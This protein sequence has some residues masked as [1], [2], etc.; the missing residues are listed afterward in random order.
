MAKKVKQI[1]NFELYFIFKLWCASAVLVLATKILRD[2]RKL[3]SL[4]TPVRYQL[5][6]IFL[7]ADTSCHLSS[8][9]VVSNINFDFRWKFLFQN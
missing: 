6:S 7:F 4:K 1:F 8:P 9:A 3:Q 5:I 2:L